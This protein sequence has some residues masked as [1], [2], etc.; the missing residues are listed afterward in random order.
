MAQIAEELSA[1]LAEDIQSEA[2]VA[3]ATGS[4]EKRRSALQDTRIRNTSAFSAGT[5]QGASGRP[6]P[7]TL[8]QNLSFDGSIEDLPG[9]AYIVNN[10]FELIWWNNKAQHFFF[11]HN[12][13]MPGDLESRN[14]LQLLFGTESAVD[15]DRMHELLIPHPAS[16]S[17]Q[18][19]PESAGT[20]ENLLGPR[21]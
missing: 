12:T 7:P 20:H 3:S 16:R 9:P 14:L 17:W 15:A 8:S 10:N 18:E 19:T 13:D 6:L 11:N 5:R 21:W 4:L 2:I 1:P